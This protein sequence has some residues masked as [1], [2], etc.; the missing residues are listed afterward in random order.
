MQY[1]FPYFLDTVAFNVPESVGWEYAN[2][3]SD[4]SPHHLNSFT[5]KLTT[6]YPRPMAH[7]MWTLARVMAVLNN[8]SELCDIN[9]IY[10][11]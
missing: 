3:S 2:V 1:L 8:K 11:Y 10:M 9:F 6:G 4:Y 7:G 5:S